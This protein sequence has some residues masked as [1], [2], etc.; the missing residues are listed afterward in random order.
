MVHVWVG[1]SF[2][3]T[4]R[5]LVFDEISN[6]IQTVLHRADKC[7]LMFFFTGMYVPPDESAELEEIEY[8]KEFCKHRF[9]AMLSD[10]KVPFDVRVVV[11]PTDSESISHVIARKCDELS[12]TIV[13]MARHSKGSLKEMWV[14]SVTKQLLRK[15]NIPVAIVPHI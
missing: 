2:H 8:T 10:A 11:G 9:V 7:S 14:G 12:A 3:S 4:L 6:M 1:M 5:I 13:V 15:A